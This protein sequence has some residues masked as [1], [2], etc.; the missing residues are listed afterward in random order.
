MMMARFVSEFPIDG[1]RRGV[2]VYLRTI[3][4]IIFYN[5]SRSRIEKEKEAFV[6]HSVGNKNTS[7]V[8]VVE[9]VVIG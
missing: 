4:F 7:K 3:K 1:R 5:L 8:N 2:C 9:D 6:S